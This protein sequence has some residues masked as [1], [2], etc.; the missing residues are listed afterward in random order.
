ME[1]QCQTLT[2]AEAAH[3]LGVSDRHLYELCRRG[4]VPAL[5]LGTRWLIPRAAL[6]RL[7]EGADQV[8]E[9]QPVGG[10]RA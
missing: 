5:R 2:V 9:P 6:E 4:Q 8:R 10:Q 1:E 3:L 7:L